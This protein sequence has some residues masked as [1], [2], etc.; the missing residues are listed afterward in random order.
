MYFVCRCKTMITSTKFNFYSYY[1]TSKT[2]ISLSRSN[3]TRSS[4]YKC[5]NIINI[6]EYL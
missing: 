1:C 3:D 2:I 4:E 6:I 5:Y